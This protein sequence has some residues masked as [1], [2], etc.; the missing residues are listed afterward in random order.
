MQQ[1]RLASTLLLLGL[2][3]TVGLVSN[4][5][6]SIF[7]INKASAQIEPLQNSDKSCIENKSKILG[8]SISEII[9]SCLTNFNDIP[10]PNLGTQELKVNAFVLSESGQSFQIILRNWVTFHSE[11][12]TVSPS[13]PLSKTFE[14]PIGTTYTVAVGNPLFAQQINWH[15]GISNCLPVLEFS[16]LGIMTDTPQQVFVIISAP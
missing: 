11:S 9:E 7:P 2:T 8:H 1:K 15:P 3:L 4:S 16:C 5:S 12:F 10:N 6:N 13:Q 14:I